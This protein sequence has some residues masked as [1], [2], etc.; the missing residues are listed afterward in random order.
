MIILCFLNDN[1]AILR[2]IKMM[3]EYEIIKH[4]KMKDIRI[5]LNA[6][7][8]RS[9]HMHHDIELMYV[10][11]GRGTIGVKGRKYHV[12]AGDTILINAY[13][14]HEIL[15]F[16]EPLT[17]I[18]LQFSGNFLKDYCHILKNTVFLDV[19]PRD[20]TPEKEYGRLKDDILDLTKEYLKAEGL[21]ELHCVRILSDILC[22][23]L[24]YL[25]VS[26]LTKEEYDRRSKQNRRIDRISTYI[27]AHYQEPIRL[28]EIASE[29]G[30]SVT[31]LS[32]FITEHFGMTFQEYL[33]DKRLECALRMI[34]D[35]SL[36]LSEISLRS[37]FSEL[38]YM[39]GAFLDT[40]GLSPNEYRR[41]GF[42]ELPANKKVNASEYIFSEKQ[43]LE[44]LD[45]LQKAD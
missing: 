41:K 15:S 10:I 22:L 29:E 5:F 21:F 9:L 45:Q 14:S 28:S 19:L 23:L 36:T 6:I 20:R 33:K 27:D 35:A 17:V 12:I 34:S 3:I 18:I 30:I 37:G 39:T 26:E 24:G 32:H 38:K 8:M 7:R 11:D 16:E 43:S 4:D 2:I 31:H 42:I 13:E 25:S 40:F 44:I 1:L